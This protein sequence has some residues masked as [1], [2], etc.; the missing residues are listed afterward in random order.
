MTAPKAVT[1][2]DGTLTIAIKALY[3]YGQNVKGVAQVVV[4]RNNNWDPSPQP[5]IVQKQVNIDGN[6]IAEFKMDSELKISSQN[7]QDE[8]KV[9]VSVAEALTGL[10]ESHFSDDCRCYSKL[11]YLLGVVLEGSTIATIRRS[12]FTVTNLNNDYNYVPGPFKLSVSF[13]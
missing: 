2:S 4:T 12:K 10:C 8:F 6:A 9:T 11:G 3:T 1:Y 13:S 5:A 7:W